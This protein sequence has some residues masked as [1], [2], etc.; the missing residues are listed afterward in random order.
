MK[1][2]SARTALGSALLALCGLSLSCAS[3]VPIKQM[4]R[5]AE[6]STELQQPYAPTR[7]LTEDERLAAEQ[8][9]A[10]AQMTVVEA[11]MILIEAERKL[12]AARVSLAEAE[13]VLEGDRTIVSEARK[14]AHGAASLAKSVLRDAGG[15]SDSG[16][17]SSEPTPH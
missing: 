5:L 16:G 1:S 6:T 8:T 4:S 2:D 9:V 7:E 3:S 17:A 12:A 15:G 14:F 13:R 11:E 10:T